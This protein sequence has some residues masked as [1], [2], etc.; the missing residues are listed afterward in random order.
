MTLIGLQKEVVEQEQEKK[1]ETKK[2]NHQPKADKYK[3]SV[4]GKRM[5]IQIIDPKRLS[6]FP[7][8]KQIFW[9]EGVAGG[10]R[11]LSNVDNY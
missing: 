3:R 2:V 8:T 11:G 1:K 6:S 10:D 9:L 5:E 7:K 4:G